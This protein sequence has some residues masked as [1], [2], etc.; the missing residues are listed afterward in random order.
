MS[1][2]AAFRS[3]FESRLRAR[4][5][6]AALEGARRGGSRALWFSLAVL[7]LAVLGI[8]PPPPGPV[9]AIAAF[10]AVLLLGSGVGA[11][12]AVSA[13][14]GAGPL[15]H[16]MDLVLR[17]P[18]LV[19]TAAAVAARPGAAGRF[20]E[21]VVDR[22]AEAVAAIPADRLGPLPRPPWR[23]L[24]IAALVAILLAILPKGGFGLLPGFGAGWGAGGS[25]DPEQA[26][27][28]KPGPDDDGK[29]KPEARSPKPEMP[30]E[31][32]PDPLLVAS[33][34]ARPLAR[35]HRPEDPILIG[36]T[37]EGL[38]GAGEGTDLELAFSV[39]GGA[40]AGEGRARRV[41]AGERV[42][43]LV[44]LRGDFAPL[45]ASLK[46]GT[47]R[48]VASLRDASGRTVAEAPPFEIR[49]E[50]QGDDG[51]KDG[52]PK[53]KPQPQPT[54]KPTPEPE[55]EPPPAPQ[56]EPEQKPKPPS[57][58]GAE[59][60]VALPPSALERRVVNPLFGEG[61]E[62]V[63]KGPILVLDPDAGRGAP[64]REMDPKEAVAE[65]RA[66]AEEAARREGADPRDL[67]TVRRYFE[68]L[69][70]IVEAGK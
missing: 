18:D 6:A 27:W 24:G 2:A 45:R 44:D 37:I 17:E 48:V 69:R 33:L 39:D 36:A 41:V 7:A 50:G 34:E 61:P 29:P 54:P 32:R 23:L 19:A 21:A 13:R 53:P 59:P 60:E 4:R 26:N 1:S 5:A 46:P 63:K 64:P 68:A 57:P 9:A 31:K 65:V 28:G 42:P 16:E 40:A 20:G 56:P 55:P 67:E 66:R 35:R 43:R 58:T 8:L 47:R 14:G 3:A 11:A 62:V 51:G 49:I 52:A 30:G 15:A 22:A 25:P 70:R 12:L 10:A 38:A